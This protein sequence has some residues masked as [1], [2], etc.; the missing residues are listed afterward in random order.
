MK[1]LYVLMLAFIVALSMLNGL[2]ANERIRN[3]EDK[4]AVSMSFEI[5]GQNKSASPPRIV[6]EYH[7]CK[8]G[9]YSNFCYRTWRIRK[10]GAKKIRVHFKWIKTQRSHDWVS[11]SAWDWWSGYRSNVWSSWKYGN[12]ITVTLIS[13]WSVT[14]E[15]FYIDYIEYEI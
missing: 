4:P 13:D 11:T 1:K 6:R 12:T 10:Y 9:R 8:S 5:Y 7:K 15:G 14:G 2:L 3:T